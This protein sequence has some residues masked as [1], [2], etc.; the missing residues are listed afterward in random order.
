MAEITAQSRSA[1]VMKLEDREE[2][3]LISDVQEA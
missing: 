3:L 1:G 2:S